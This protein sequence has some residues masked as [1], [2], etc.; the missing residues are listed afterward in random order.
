MNAKVSPSSQPKNRPKTTPSDAPRAGG[1]RGRNQMESLARGAQFRAAVIAVLTNANRT[2]V[3]PADIFMSPGVAALS[4]LRAH[5]DT[6][7]WTMKQNRLVER[8]TLTRPSGAHETGYILPGVKV[9]A[10]PALPVPVNGA[11]VNGVEVLNATPKKR[12]QATMP[13]T[14]PTIRVD[15]DRTNGRLTFQVIGNLLLDLGFK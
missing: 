4:M 8:V 14:G 1:Q 6:A 5:F 15:V 9:A 13:D 11:Q 7:L 10:A 2:P 3:R 12:K